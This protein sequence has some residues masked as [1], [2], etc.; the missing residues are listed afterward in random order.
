MDT[1][2][3]S[4]V[5]SLEGILRKEL[6][7]D[8]F[9][10]PCYAWKSPEE[11][12]R[13]YGMILLARTIDHEILALEKRMR[14]NRAP[15]LKYGVLREGG[16]DED[17]P[18][19]QEDIVLVTLYA[20]DMFHAL[21][22]FTIDF[23]QEDESSCMGVSYPKDYVCRASDVLEQLIYDEHG[24]IDIVGGVRRFA[25][26]DLGRYKLVPMYHL[27]LNSEELHLYRQLKEQGECSDEEAP[28]FAIP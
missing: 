7:K 17:D 3:D 6:K 23:A 10:L 19:W 1:E 25:N 15:P 9:E 27:S 24:N 11:N 21:W 16:G 12:A 5:W 8:G 28:Q 20:Y 4:N 22:V 13:T 2:R 14:S 26:M 18:M